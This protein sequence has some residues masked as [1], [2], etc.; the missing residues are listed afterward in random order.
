MGTYLCIASNNVPPT[1][2]KRYSVQVHCTYLSQ[3]YC[4][5]FNQKITSKGETK[6]LTIYEIILI[7]SFNI[8]IFRQIIQTIIIDQKNSRQSREQYKSVIVRLKQYRSIVVRLVVQTRYDQASL[9]ITYLI[10]SYGCFY[11]YSFTC[12]K[13][14]KS[15]SSS[16]SQQ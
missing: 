4:I 9:S 14:N 5:N 16:S 11:Y 15:I 7:I 6:F 8:I 3:N 2:S 10:L 13:S 1:V 12:Y